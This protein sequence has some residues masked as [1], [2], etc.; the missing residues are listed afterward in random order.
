MKKLCNFQFPVSVYQPFFS[1][2][3][4]S[5]FSAAIWWLADRILSISHLYRALK[6]ADE[7]VFMKMAMRKTL[8]LPSHRQFFSDN[9]VFGKESGSHN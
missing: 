4:S 7:E 3:F 2:R 5:Q 8:Q 6:R 1:L 9:G